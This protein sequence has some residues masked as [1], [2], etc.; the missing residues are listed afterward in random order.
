[1]RAKP[2]PLILTDNNYTDY[3]VDDYRSYGIYVLYTVKSKKYQC[4]NCQQ[5]VDALKAVA[6]SH[7]KFFPGST[8]IFFALCVFEDNQYAFGMVF[9]YVI[10]S[11]NSID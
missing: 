6:A 7:E 1:M 9:L 11:L 8:D 3:T 10:Y 2:Q 5:G 4:R